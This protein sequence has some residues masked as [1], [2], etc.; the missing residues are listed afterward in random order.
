AHAGAGLSRDDTHPAT[1]A[2]VR[3]VALLPVKADLD[4]AEP[5]FDA[6]PATRACSV[7]IRDANVLSDNVP[8]RLITPASAVRVSV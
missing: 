1:A 8:S 3:A 6:G 2:V 4:P 7:L 5:F